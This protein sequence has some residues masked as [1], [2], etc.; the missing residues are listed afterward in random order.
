MNTKLCF[1][2]KSLCLFLLKARLLLLNNGK[3][4]SV[5]LFLINLKDSNE[6][7]NYT[8]NIKSDRKISECLLKE[9][10]HE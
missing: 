10:L 5:T 1:K 6:D 9:E 8:L 2:L 7:D 3:L 4:M